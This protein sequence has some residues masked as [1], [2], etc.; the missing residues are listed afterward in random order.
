[1]KYILKYHTVLF[2][3]IILPFICPRISSSQNITALNT[4]QQ[5]LVQR[6]TS[7][8]QN[9]RIEIKE[10]ETPAK[11][12]LNLTFEVLRNYQQLSDN[13][14]ASMKKLL[15]GP[16]RQT[17][18]SLGHFTVH[19]DTVGN[20]VPSLL[21]ASFKRM[22]EDTS[23][24][25]NH[26]DSINVINAFVDSTLNIFNYV[27]DIV[28]NS[29]GYLPPPF[30][31]GENTYNVYL[32]E[33]GGGLYG[34]TVPTLDPINP[35][36]TPP[37]YTSYIEI[38]NDFRS[39][40]STSRG[41][42]GVKVTAAHEFHHAI[43]LGSYGYR[44]NDRY[45]YEITSTWIEDLLYNEIN[46]YYQYI[47]YSNDQPR[48]H[49]AYPNLSFIYSD[50]L[51]EYSRAI[52]GKFI[53]EKYSSTVMR[54]TWENLRSSG[55]VKALDD[56]L[57][58]VG[59]TLRIAFVEF[60][61]WNYFTGSRS[62]PG[63]YYSEAS[64][65]PLI[66]ERPPIE[67]T[68]NYRILNDSTETFSSIYL[69][70][71]HDNIPSNDVINNINLSS[72]QNYL[73][74][75]Y[76]FHYEMTNIG[77]DTFRQLSNG[78]FVKLSVSDPMNWSSGGIITST[79]RSVTVYPN[80]CIIN[81]NTNINFTIPAPQNKSLTQIPATLYIYNAGMELVGSFEKDINTT[82]PKINWDLVD[83]KGDIISSGIYLY[84]I[85]FDNQEY[86]GK[87]AVIKK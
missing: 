79:Q 78:V 85:I 51:I 67:M 32:T 57:V 75:N 13:L 18:K 6:V 27:W 28:V 59:S 71:I 37:R 26:T 63:R 76:L 74:R 43:Q 47:K 84:M 38:D 52:W 72:A 14:K 44:E 58:N 3:L 42:P 53:Q 36:Q 11:C 70:I 69:N 49:F 23:Y 40:Y 31:T 22:L 19:Y 56:A 64:N 62:M 30:E 17:F 16:G 10:G 83:K 48:G 7:W 21:T 46:D 68:G 9:N 15:Q 20:N 12:A 61:R 39:V 2:F 65:Y 66:K 50:G 82:D 81:K 73:I 55:S 34:Q 86:S 41:L 77:D 24:V 5:S 1:V 54:N 29:S 45:F 35:G 60:S 25:K 4:E 80:P 8:R 33:L 87:F